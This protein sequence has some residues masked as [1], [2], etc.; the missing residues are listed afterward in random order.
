VFADR[1]A[2]G[3]S[4]YFGFGDV[5]GDG[6]KDIASA[7]KQGDWFAWW[8]PPSNR[9]QSWKKHEIATDQKGAT[10]ILMGDINQ[11]GKVDFVAARGHGRGLVWYEAPFWRAREITPALARPHSLA[12]GD[13]D[14]DGDLDVVSCF[15]G[16][17]II[18][19]FENDGRGNFTMHFIYKDQ[20]AY[21]IRLI[22]MDRDGDLD[23][24]VAGDRSKNVVWYENRLPKR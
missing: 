22:D 20:T 19:W 5:N 4:H 8:E 1:D 18:A 21:D 23:I 15:N 13:I 12:I 2:S 24:L 10:H 3:L 17:R 7:A 16:D 9:T 14:G 6:R 11:D